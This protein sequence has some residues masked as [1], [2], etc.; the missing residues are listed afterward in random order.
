VIELIDSESGAVL[1]RGVDTRAAQ[2]PGYTYQSN[3]VTN[4][5]E[6]RRLFSR[7]ANMLVDALNDLRLLESDTLQK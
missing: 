4:T 2:T 3:S 6:A 5:A 7:W 1:I